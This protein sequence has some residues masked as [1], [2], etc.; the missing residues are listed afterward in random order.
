[1]CPRRL[2][3][4][5]QA[6]ILTAIL[7]PRVVV[8]RAPTLHD[9]R[10]SRLSTSHTHRTA[11]SIQS[12]VHSNEWHRRR[13]R[14]NEGGTPPRVMA[15]SP[16]HYSTHS[17]LFSS[18]SPATHRPVRRARH[19]LRDLV[20]R[21]VKEHNQSQIGPFLSPS[22]VEQVTKDPNYLGPLI[23]FSLLCHLF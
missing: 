18:I 3:Q 6:V 10:T 15:P 13:T 4:P 21:P 22:G 12:R 2:V 1:M 16:R 14:N 20:C 11:S 19:S 17:N 8:D 5:N 23:F 9:A 7:L